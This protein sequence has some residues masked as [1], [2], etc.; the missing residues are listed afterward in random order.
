MNLR[1]HA[2]RLWF[3][4]AGL[5]AVGTWRY[6]EIEGVRAAEVGAVSEVGARAIDLED[7]YFGLRAMASELQRKPRYD[8]RWEQLRREAWSEVDDE[9]RRTTTSKLA[10]DPRWMELYRRV[11]LAVAGLNNAQGVLKAERADSIKAEK[12][13]HIVRSFRTR[14]ST[15]DRGSI[16]G[17]AL[18]LLA[19][20]LYRPVRVRLPFHLLAGWVRPSSLL[21]RRAWDR[22]SGEW[23]GLDRT[24]RA[25]CCILGTACALTLFVLNYSNLRPGY[26]HQ[27]ELLWGVL[28]PTGIMALV[29]VLALAVPRSRRGD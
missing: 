2:G 7:D 12:L 26:S 22:R 27:K 16:L 29:A 13:L 10:T 9:M 14:R 17:A 6:V 8:A 15:I 11:K 19:A 3:I 21:V 24:Q 25:A 23:L 4:L 20:T 1:V 28:A 5:V 18:V